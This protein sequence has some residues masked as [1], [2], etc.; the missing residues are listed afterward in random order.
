LDGIIG[1]PVIIRVKDTF[2]PNLRE[3]LEGLNLKTRIMPRFNMASAFLT[4]GI[5]NRIAGLDFVEGIYLDREQRIPEI[6]KGFGLND[7]ILFQRIL[8][9]PRLRQVTMPRINQADPSWV[10]TL[11]AKKYQ[12]SDMAN[13]AGFN[14]KGMK[15]AIVDSD[16]GPQVNLMRQLKGRVQS[17][18]VKPLYGATCGHGS[19][20]T[21]E[22]IGSR[23]ELPN[24]ILEG[25]AP[26]AEAIAIKT[27]FTPMGMGASSDIIK[28]L[29]IALDCGADVISLSLGSPPTDPATD[30]LCIAISQISKEKAVVCVASGN[31]GGRV[32]SPA[33]CPNALAIGA[34]DSRTNQLASFSN[35]GPEQAFIA[36]GVNIFSSIATES[37]LDIVSMGGTGLSPLSG[38]S[39]STPLVASQVLLIMEYFQKDYNLR[40][41]I[42]MIRDMGKRYGEQ[43]TDERGY[44]P[45]KFSYAEKYAKEVLS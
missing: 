4:T 34:V 19:F 43:K 15:I 39:M 30:P 33:N 38:T 17:Q 41:T 1:A 36:P 37:F 7:F 16:A 45:L 28:G 8:K 3:T 10:G 5:I 26:Q 31:D 12:E 20:C 25:V 32:G 40:P 6:P 9:L 14:G 42:D 24:I 18:Y 2:L 11:E 27:L 21:T 35:R 29:E 22:A 23:L 13:Q 44:G